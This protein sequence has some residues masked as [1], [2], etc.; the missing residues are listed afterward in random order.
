ML[1]CLIGIIGVARVLNFSRSLSIDT[2]GLRETARVL[3]DIIWS[4]GL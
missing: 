1:I 3:G 2:V 4:S